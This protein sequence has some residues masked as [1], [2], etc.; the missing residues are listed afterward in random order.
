[1]IESSE[2]ILA[3]SAVLAVLCCWCMREQSSSLCLSLCDYCWCWLKTSYLSLPTGRVTACNRVS[4][5]FQLPG[6]HLPPP[7]VQLPP[8]AA[9]PRRPRRVPLAAPGGREA[10]AQQPRAGLRSPLL[11]LCPRSG[12]LNVV[13]RRIFLFQVCWSPLP[14]STST[15]SS[16]GPVSRPSTCPGPRTWRGCCCAR[17]R[18]W[19]RRACTTRPP[20]SPASP[21]LCR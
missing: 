10:G 6:R 11:L 16:L 1:M 4:Q 18:G 14:H 19:P 7:Q 8:L 20:R 15:C 3:G 21:Q 12:D 17:A 13:Y 9:R 5:Q 2:L